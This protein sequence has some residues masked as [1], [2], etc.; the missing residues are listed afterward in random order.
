[1]LMGLNLQQ[2]KNLSLAD[3]APAGV[4]SLHALQDL[5]QWKRALVVI[6][7]GDIGR[8][9]FLVLVNG[10]FLQLVLVQAAPASSAAVLHELGDLRNDK[11]RKQTPF[12][13]PS[14]GM[15]GLPPAGEQVWI[16]LVNC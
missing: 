13:D 2:E 11:R 10:E 4:Q 8:H 9:T 16:I 1:M 5:Q 6:S 12:N 3:V 7:R 15:R 14:A